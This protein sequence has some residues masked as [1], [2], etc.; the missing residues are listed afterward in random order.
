MTSLPETLILVFY[1]FV[2]S[3]LAIYG[4]HRYYLIRLYTRNRDRV[5]A[6]LPPPAREN[7]PPVTIQ[8][9][10]YNEMYVANRLI[11][12]L[13]DAHHYPFSRFDDRDRAIAWLAS[14]EPALGLRD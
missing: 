8:L 9:P 7:L 2:L 13:I 6:D 11:E 5:P 1:F 14:N 12:V 3:I 4:W 10:I